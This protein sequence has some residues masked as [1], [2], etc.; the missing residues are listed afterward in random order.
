[1]KKYFIILI[2][3]N[4][5]FNNGFIGATDIDRKE[6]AQMLEDLLCLPQAEF[7]TKHANFF[8]ETSGYDLAD[9]FTQ[10]R[11]FT[12]LKV[13]DDE[14]DVLQLGD[15]FYKG[16][17]PKEQLKELTV[18]RANNNY[19]Q[20]NKKA[21]VNFKKF[22]KQFVDGAKTLS[23]SL[24]N[25]CFTPKKGK[26]SPELALIFGSTDDVTFTK[27]EPT[28]PHRGRSTTSSPDHAA[29]TTPP[30]KQKKFVTKVAH[31][32]KVITFDQ[33]EEAITKQPLSAKFSLLSFEQKRFIGLATMASVAAIAGVAVNAT[34]LAISA[35]D[36]MKKW[37]KDKKE[38]QEQQAQENLEQHMPEPL[39]SDKPNKPS[40][41]PHHHNKP[42]KP[43]NSSKPQ[44][45]H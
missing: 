9:H 17:G 12:P 32:N 30:E 36:H 43:S 31:D 11:K 39:P 1:M 42:P 16:K 5:I 37:W 34:A 24:F 14:E 15:N 40:H 21:R 41:H 44:S 28:A 18:V 20:G 27:K 23:D 38:K 33:L 45:H 19:F 22:V 25:L 8:A 13:V 3:S 26:Y 10:D 29:E 7:E 4:G 2:F 6:A 35:Y